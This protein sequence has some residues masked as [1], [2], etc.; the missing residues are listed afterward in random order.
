MKTKKLILILS[1]CL[2]L[3]V[4]SACSMGGNDVSKAYDTAMNEMKKGNY[5]QAA[6]V[7]S[8]ISFYEDSLNLSQYCRAQAYASEEK[9]DDALQ[10]LMEIGNYR[11]SAQCYAYYY[12]RSNENEGATPFH[13]AYTADLYDAELLHGFRDASGRARIIREALYQEGIEA[14]EQED[15]SQASTIFNALGRYQDSNT[16]YQY[17]EG[18]IAEAEGDQKTDAYAKATIFYENAGQFS[19]SKERMEDCLKKAREKADALINDGEFD[20]AEVIIETLGH[21]YGENYLTRIGDA[22]EQARQDEI[23]RQIKKADALVEA[24][25]YDEAREIYLSVG[26]NKKA[27]DT[28]RMKAE[29]LGKEGNFDEAREIFLELGDKEQGTEMLYLKANVLEKEGNKQEAA[30]L[31]YSIREY[32]DS[33]TKHFNIGV[34]MIETDPAIASAILLKDKEYEGTVDLLYQIADK[35]SSEGNYTLSVLVFSELGSVKDCKLRMTKDLY[36]YGKQLLEDGQNEEAAA[37]FEKLSGVGSADLYQNMA[38]YAAA[39]KLEADGAYSGAA[40]AFALLEDYKDSKERSQKCTYAYGIE[41]K[42]AAEYAMAIELFSS[43]GQYADSEKQVVEC[44]YLWACLLEEGKKWSE[45]ISLFAGLNEYRD[46]AERFMACNNQLGESQLVDGESEKAYESFS[47]GGDVNGQARAALAVAEMLK[48]ELKLADALEWYQKA[49][50]LPETEKETIEIASSL[51]EIEEDELAEGYAS[52]IIGS[53]KNQEILYTLAI[54][55]LERQDEDAAM[56]QMQKAGDNADASERFKEMLKTRVDTLVA[57]EKYEAAAELC[58]SFGDQEQADV[59]LK[60][61]EEKEEEERLR[62]EEANRAAHQERIDEANSYVEQKEYDAAAEIFTEIG[63]EELAEQVLAQKKAEEEAERE[64]EEEE[65][66]RQYKA[67]E[68]DGNALLAAGDYEGAIAVFKELGNQDMINE[69][70]YQKAEAL[71]QPDLYLGISDYKDSREKHYLAGKKLIETDPEQAF[72]IMAADIAYENTQETLYELADKESKAGNYHLSSTIF[73]TLS[74]QPLDMNALRPDCNMR[75][76]Q[77]MYQYGL[78]LKENGEWKLA[79]EIF[80]ELDGLGQSGKYLDE[81]HY[82]IADELEKNGKYA[83][84]ALSFEALG[85]YSDAAERAK[86]NRYKEALG[87]MEKKEFSQAKA[88]LEVLG[89]YKDSVNKITEC[90]YYLGCALFD[91]GEYK[92]AID[93]FVSAENYEDVGEKIKACYDG[94]GD[95]EISSAEQMIRQNYVLQ[96]AKAGEKAYEYYQKADD[97]DKSISAALLTA[98]CYQKESNLQEAIPWYLKTGEKGQPFLSGITNYF[99]ITEQNDAAE[100]M[101]KKINDEESKE[102]LYTIANKKLEEGDLEGALQLFA[103]NGDYTAETLPVGEFLNRYGVINRKVDIYNGPSTS[104]SK[105]GNPIAASKCVYLIMNVMNDDGEI[106]TRVNYKDNIGYI[107]SDCITLLDENASRIYDDA[108][109]TPAP[110]Y[111]A[112]ESLPSGV[113]IN[114]YGSINHY[115]NLRSGPSVDSKLAGEPLSVGKRV[116]IV[117]NETNARGEIWLKVRYNN[118]DGYIK[119]EYIDLVSVEKSDDASE[120]NEEENNDLTGKPR[121]GIS[122]TTS[123]GQGGTYPRGVYV[124]E[125][126]KKSPADK[127]GVKA[128]DIIVEVNGQIISSVN[129][130]VEI[131]SQLR[132][133]DEVALK[134]FRPARVTDAASGRISTDGKYV[135]VT[136]TLAMLDAEGK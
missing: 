34:G 88:R 27:D 77:D 33:R 102:Q 35:A 6:E 44:T 106:W 116:Y 55:S 72:K 91:R 111:S 62:A 17:A 85:T 53:E 66:R 89:Q 56:R 99:I 24:K 50:I 65:K 128:G 39:E 58:A 43:L 71:N 95:A 123:D 25:N 36:L 82:G 42:K 68:E 63:E 15:W 112:V 133:G 48:S 37:A 86:E 94:L 103:E 74:L 54:R 114:Q 110:I 51:L 52:V 121:M 87:L 100:E 41:K 8:G 75:A 83:Q 64:K 108:Q 28:L 92:Q 93:I 76:I 69:V 38:R 125:V 60:Q 2:L 136:V 61:K 101:L 122:V 47:I 117:L 79:A 21:R 18:R 12:A 1:L 20:D 19:D 134:V 57:Q 59:L 96:A 26:E 135:D 115:V 98:S 129:D 104:S 7:L 40:T 5:A 78:S 105:N 119:S 11:D 126:E 84:A 13:R 130:E 70:I 81:T 97:K 124:I 23:N 32:K 45:A 10:I 73:S 14:E 46:S 9:Y 132:E 67:R 127:G 90:Q 16:R 113:P 4:L 49:I 30:D 31:F 3:I 29:T 118:K 107:S 22:R 131:I 109:T 80:K 120:T